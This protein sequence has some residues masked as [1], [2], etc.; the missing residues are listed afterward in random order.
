[1]SEVTLSRFLSL[2][3]QRLFPEPFSIEKALREVGFRYAIGVD[4]AGTGAFFGPIHAAAV[5]FDLSDLSNYF[6]VKESKQLTERKREE[7]FWKIIETVPRYAISEVNVREIEAFRNVQRA[8]ALARWRAVTQLV[9]SCDSHPTVLLI[10]HFP[11]KDSPFPV[12][13]ISHGDELVQC[14]A[15]ASILAKVTRDW[16]VKAIAQ[17]PD[18]ACYGIDSNKGYRCKAH[19]S[20]IRKYGL[21]PL[22]RKHMPELERLLS[23]R[24]V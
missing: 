17:L 5:L 1:M 4:E 12:L 2:C 18:F 23:G 24:E 15:Y 13:A 21:S 14:I 20:A 10:D 9:S 22:H 7:L 19:W 6:E 3:T 8:G 11:M 16:V